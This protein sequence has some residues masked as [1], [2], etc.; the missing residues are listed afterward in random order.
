VPRTVLEWRADPGSPWHN[1]HL[2]G[3]EQELILLCAHGN[4]SSLAAATLVDL[5]FEQVG[6]VISGFEAWHRDGP[7]AAAPLQRDGLP[8][9]GPP[10]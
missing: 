8:G 1:P 5:G 6:D 7:V 10:D 3:L 9:S 4:S 2:G